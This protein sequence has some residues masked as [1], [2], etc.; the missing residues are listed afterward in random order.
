MNKLFKNGVALLGLMVA[1]A[2][3]VACAESDSASSAA[4]S[5][6][7]QSSNTVNGE[8][9]AD[10]G[11]L[12]Q[13]VLKKIT[14]VRPDLEFGELSVTPVKG[15]YKTSLPDGGVIYI[16]E[17]GGH[18]F[19]GA[20]Y[21]VQA[22]GIV[23]LDELELEAQRVVALADVPTEDMIVFA[24]EVTKAHVYVFTDVDCYYCQKLHNEVPAL[25]ELGVEVRYLAYPRAGIGSPSYR[26]IASAWCADDRLDSLTR[27]KA[28]EK[29]DDNVCDP[30][31]VSD[32]YQLGG[33]LG[34]TGTPALIT[35]SGRL[36]PGYMPADRLAK[37]L[38]L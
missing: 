19:E 24:P 23:N 11:Q 21:E 38:G 6:S 8:P 31:P 14:E 22:G 34:V 12:T 18:F 28:G 26:K 9:S 1:M 37:A 36:L 20:L 32:Q 27:L 2:T 13:A 17:D 3:M 35:S 29:I 5:L 4:E 25:N 33:S 30:N 15:I 10:I 7:N 16:T